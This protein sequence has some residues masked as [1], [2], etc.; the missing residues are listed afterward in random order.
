MEWL[1]A[2][3][4]TIEYIESHLDDDITLNDL[5][6][7]VHISPYILGKGFAVM[8][9]CSVSEYI[10]NR[11]LYLAALSL[12]NTDKSVLEA[13]LDAHSAIWLPVKRK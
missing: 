4:G 3:R 6:D 10:R 13:A 1:S 7:H 2:I 9:G 8:T 12:R 5:S 11:R